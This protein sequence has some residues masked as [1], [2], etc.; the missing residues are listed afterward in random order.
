MNE[1]SKFEIFRKSAKLKRI[2]GKWWSQ[3]IG[4]VYVLYVEND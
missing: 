3:G 2:K 1:K 4:R